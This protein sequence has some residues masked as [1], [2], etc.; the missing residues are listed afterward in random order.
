[1]RALLLDFQLLLFLC[2]H[3]DLA[4][5]IP[6]ICQALQDPDGK[7]AEGDDMWIRSVAGCAGF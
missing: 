6:R 7:I 4:H 1:L 3:M 2:D 5:D